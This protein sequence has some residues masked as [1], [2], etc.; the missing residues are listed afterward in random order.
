M[1]SE[2]AEKFCEKSFSGLW[3]GVHTA[4]YSVILET[5]TIY[6]CFGKASNLEMKP[7]NSTKH[8]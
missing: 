8:Q 3:P 7:E 5:L 1:A 4:V 2:M 6:Q